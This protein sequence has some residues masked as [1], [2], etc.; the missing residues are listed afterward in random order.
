M[1]QWWSWISDV[2][3]PVAVTFYLLTRMENK[4]DTLIATVQQLVYQ[5]PSVISRRKQAN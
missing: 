3:F 4:L 5:D 2:G 1:E